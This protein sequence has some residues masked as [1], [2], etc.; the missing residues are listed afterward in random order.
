MV[1]DASKPSIEAEHYQWE[2]AGASVDTSSVYQL[3]SGPSLNIDPYTGEDVSLGFSLLLL[4]QILN[5][6]YT[7]QYTSLI[8]KIGTIQGQLADGVH[9]TVIWSC[10][11]YLRSETN[12]RIKVKVF[13]FD[14]A[15]LSK[16]V[17]DKK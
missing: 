15:Y 10:R 5:I 11:L 8:L 17:H 7:P 3:P 9:R 14:D 12:R 6:D 1:E 2:W 16:V 13:L 4:H